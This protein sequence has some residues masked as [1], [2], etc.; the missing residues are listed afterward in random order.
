VLLGSFQHLQTVPPIHKVLSAFADGGTVFAEDGFEEFDGRLKAC[1]GS[2][3]DTI[4]RFM[5]HAVFLFVG[6]RRR[7]AG[8]MV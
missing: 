8:V 1:R 6:L 5:R 4:C 3:R 7:A 2:H